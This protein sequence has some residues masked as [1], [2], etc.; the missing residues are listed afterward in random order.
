MADPAS[1]RPKSSDIPTDPGVYRFKDAHGRIIYVGKANNLRSRL[2]SYFVNPKTLPPKTRT[3]VHTAA[4][5][6]W[7]VVASEQEAIQLEYTWIKEFTP[8]FNIMYRDDKTYPYLAVTMNE[9]YPRVM[10]MRGDRRKGVK[11]FGPFHP[12]KAIRETVDRML[13]VFPVRTCS[14]GVFRRAQ[15]ANRPCLMGYIDKCAAPCVGRISQEDH[16]ALAEDFVAFMNGDVRPYLRE[17]EEQMQQAVSELRYEDAGRYRDDIEALKK[18]FERNAVVLPE[19]TE[20]DIFAF[21]EDE[22]EA[23]FQVF[24]VRNGR[25]RGQRGWVVEKV[26][27]TT[28][29]QLVEQLL[30]QVYGDMEDSERIPREV[31]VPVLPENAGDVE[32]W[33]MKRRGAHVDL[34]V[35]QRGTKRQLMETVQENADGALRLHKSR[36]SGD[37]TARSAA[38]RELQEALELDQ[39]LLRIEA[40][41]ISHV[42]GTNVVGSMVVFEDG[43]PKKRDYRKFN[44]TGDAARDD[45]AAMDD[46]LTRRFKNYLRE[47]SDAPLVLSGELEPDDAATAEEQRK[48]SYPPSLVVVD[49]GLAQVNAAQQALLNLG[50]DDVPVVGLAKRLEELWIPGDE[51]PMI[52]PRTSQ[53]LYLL[54]RL[55]DESHRFAIQAHRAKRSKSMINSVLDTVPGLG[56]RRRQDL[57]KHFGSLKKIRAAS[58]EE[59][60]AVSGIGPKLAQTI[61]DALSEDSTAKEQGKLQP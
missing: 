60:Q 61:V 33:M 56:E 41:D 3:M 52:L 23:A 5:V 19:S 20:A 2:S 1:Y 50:V 18:V 45:T 47:Q 55:R 12:A 27:D 53:G 22:L 16:Y 14:A 39:P 4:A 35:P 13:R 26:D 34:R 57:L 11:Y 31:L 25:I 42:Q 54:Q 24:H 58:T 46:V 10:V 49:G 48:F 21:A 40:F 17:L 28:K 43:L 6:E 8:R 9:K 44:V 37:I 38:L 30:L 59:L 51:F 29:S 7:T 36:R 32:A 15:R